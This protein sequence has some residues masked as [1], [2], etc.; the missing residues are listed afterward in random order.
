MENN[1]I[2]KTENV[3]STEEPIKVTRKDDNKEF[4]NTNSL[5]PVDQAVKSPNDISTTMVP[6]IS[7]CAVFL[8]VAII[9]IVFRKK[10]YLGKSKDSKE[11]MVRLNVNTR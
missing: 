4:D 10:I 1:T 3:I 5:Q 9:A 8:T 2:E 6:I 7:V 11:D